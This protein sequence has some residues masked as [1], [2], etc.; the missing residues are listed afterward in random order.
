MR[1]VE[2]RFFFCRQHTFPRCNRKIFHHDCQGLDGPP[3][4]AAKPL[5]GSF[6]RSI[7]AQVKSAD[8]LDSDDAT[9]AQDTAGFRNRRMPPFCPAQQIYFRAAVIAADRLGIISPRKRIFIFRT[10]GRTHGKFAHTGSFP[11][12]RHGIQYSHTRP[13]GR[14]VNKRMQITAIRPIK[15]LFLTAVANGY[16][17]RNENISPLPFA[18]NNCKICIWRPLGLF[19]MNGQN[20]RP[21]R[22]LFLQVFLKLL[23]PF[24]GPLQDNFHI[25]S[26]I[27]DRAIQPQAP[28]QAAH[29]RTKAN[30]LYDAKY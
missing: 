5:N 11:V 20:G 29:E 1:S 10:A 25:R 23:P 9:A 6:I 13:A 15:E 24:S 18:F 26:L 19:R 8:S 28:G 16:I 4:Q 27:A 21:F 30:A 7:T 14:T 17:G 12:I 2:H 22:R 3:F